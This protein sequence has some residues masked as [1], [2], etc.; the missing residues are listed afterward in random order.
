[1]RGRQKDKLR[2]VLVAR[3]FGALER[4][5]GQTRVPLRLLFSLTYDRDVLVRYRAIEAIGRVADGLAADDVEKVRVFI[6]GLIWL[7]TEES[8][9]IGWHAPEAIAEICVRVPAFFEEYARLLPQFL[10][11]ESFVASTCGALHRL[12]P[13]PPELARDCC[14]RL[15]A[16]S[17]NQEKFQTYDSGTG[18]LAETTV[19]RLATQVAAGCATRQPENAQAAAGHA[20]EVS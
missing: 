17:E 20:G 4:W 9:G 13:L 16:L 18:R 2:E 11:E 1:M 8:G 3:D 10:E 14:S 12:A 15:I 7:M 19:G 5:A 6:R